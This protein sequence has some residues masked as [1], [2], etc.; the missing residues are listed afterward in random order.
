MGIIRV[1][2]F[3]VVIFRVG[4]TLGGNFP[5]GNCPGGIYPGW[6]LSWVEIFFGGGFP[7]GN[8]PGGIIRVAIFRVG[9]FMLPLL[10]VKN[11]LTQ[12]SQQSQS[13]PINQNNLSIVLDGIKSLLRKVNET[14]VLSFKL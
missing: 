13:N 4:V 7:D 9:V 6:E 8:S 3:R 10:V 1:G 5:G 11:K 12:N 2:N 14:I